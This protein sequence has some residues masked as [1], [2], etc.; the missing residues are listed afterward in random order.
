M[1]WTLTDSLDDYLAGAGPYLRADPVRH[2]VELAAIERML[3]SGSDTF[4]EGTPVFGWWS[5][6]GTASAACF[7]TPPYPLL[8]SGAVEAVAPLAAE[9]AR[10]QRSLPGVNGP[11]ELAESFAAAWQEQAGAGSFVERRSRLFVLDQLIPPEPRP[12][13]RARLATQ[14]DT[15]L[16]TGW[17]AQFYVDMGESH[18]D[19]QGSLRD[20]LSFD[21]LM[22]WETDGGTPVS[23]AGHNRPAAG[24]T[25][26]GPVYTPEA[27]RR[28]G[29]GA[30]VTVAISQAALDQG[31]TVVLFTD[32]AN[33][34]SN[35]LYQRLGYRAV[36]DR[37]VLGFSARSCS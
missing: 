27:L 18:G 36:A 15:E 28:R 1:T 37:L 20:Q 11:A 23:M 8:L 25:R 2:T 29:Y 22:L 24:V 3:I 13:G 32:L 4:G 16:L 6:G 33:P 30:A 34:T 17:F 21:G 9:L 31:A 7:H 12:A 5:A 26:V 10:R 14:A 35:A 19:P